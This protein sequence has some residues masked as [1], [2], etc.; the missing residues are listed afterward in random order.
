MVSSL[1]I[2]RNSS[3]SFSI[4]TQSNF[5]SLD[6]YL[7]HI[8]DTLKNLDFKLER[9]HT[10]AI[11]QLKDTLTHLQ[12]AQIKRAAITQ[13]IWDFYP[14]PQNVIDKMLDLAQ[15]CPHHCILEPSAGSGDL[16]SAIAN[17][18]VSKIDCFELHPLLQK[19]LILQRFNVL[20]DDFLKSQP[21]PIYD[22]V[23]ANPP[24][25]SNGVNRHTRQ[26]FKFL[27]PGG[28]L[29][30]L[31]HHYQLKPS[32]GDRSF[33]AWLQ[34]NNARFLNCG[35]AFINSDRKTNVPLQIIVIDKL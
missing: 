32:P 13:G 12:V 21:Q 18:G 16:A 24:F 19:A 26:A 33:F 8:N 34:R 9:S 35:Q 5:A 14:T 10:S 11:A 7:H 30:T 28:R 15:L 2:L 27:K 29:I 1:P 25:S 23:L 4:S 20:G 31:A 17:L 3:R 22:R 6:D